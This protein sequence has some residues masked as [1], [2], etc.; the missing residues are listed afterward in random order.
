MELKRTFIEQLG[1]KLC[2][3]EIPAAVESLGDI[4]F[5]SNHFSHEQKSWSQKRWKEFVAGRLCSQEAL[6]LLG[7]PHTVINRTNS[8][9]PLWPSSVT[10]SISHSKSHAFACVGPREDFKSIGLD[11][12]ICISETRCEVLRRQVLVDSELELLKEHNS[13][14]AVATLMF[15]AKEALYKLINPLAHTYMIFSEG[16]VTSIDVPKRRFS[17]E[18]SSEKKELNPFLSVYHGHFDQIENNILALLTI[19]E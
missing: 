2:Y 9:A 5:L 8:G 14:L 11:A 18:L 17:I 7:L 12:E 15:S 19:S 16:R 6:H 3:L 10:G 1:L 13:D 4:S